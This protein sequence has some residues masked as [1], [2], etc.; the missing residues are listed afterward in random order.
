MRIEKFRKV[1]TMDVTNW[2]IAKEVIGEPTVMAFRLLEDDPL[3]VGDKVTFDL[4]I[5]VERKA[6]LLTLEYPLRNL[7]RWLERIG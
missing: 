7:P 1:K 2:K 4:R 5:L 3:Q 6:K